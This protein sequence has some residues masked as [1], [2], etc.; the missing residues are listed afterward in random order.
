M[1]SF[2]KVDAIRHD[3]NRKHLIDWGQVEAGE[4]FLQTGGERNRVNII[5]S[6]HIYE[7][8]FIVRNQSEQLN[9]LADV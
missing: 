7:I 8:A 9:W 2:G 5:T 4:G 6:L 1:G 3:R